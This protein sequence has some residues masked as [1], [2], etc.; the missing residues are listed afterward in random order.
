MAIGYLLHSSG[1]Q[2]VRD[3]GK[4]VISDGTP[5]PDCDC[6]AADPCDITCYK[7]LGGGFAP[8]CITIAVAGLQICTG[9]IGFKNVISGDPGASSDYDHEQ[10]GTAPNGSY[11]ARLYTHDLHDSWMY[12]QP[13]GGPVSARSRES[14]SSLWFDQLSVD[15]DLFAGGVISGT[16][17]GHWYVIV[18]VSAGGAGWYSDP[19]EVIRDSCG[20]LILDGTTG[21]FHG[22][23]LPYLVGGEQVEADNCGPFTMPF[24]ERYP[25]LTQ[26]WKP[27]NITGGTFSITQC[28]CP[29]ETGRC[30]NYFA[31]D[32]FCE[33]STQGPVR[34]LGS[35]CTPKLTSDYPVWTSLSPV[36]A[37]IVTRII[38]ILG[39]ICLG[40]GFCAELLDLPDPPAFRPPECKVQ[41]EDCSTCCVPFTI[42]VTGGDC[43]GVYVMG[44]TG[45]FSCTYRGEDGDGVAYAWCDEDGWHVVIQKWVTIGPLRVLKTCQFDGSLRDC[46]DQVTDWECTSG[47]TESPSIDVTCGACTCTCT[48]Y[49]VSGQRAFGTD[50][51]PLT[52]NVTDPV[53]CLFEPASLDFCPPTPVPDSIRIVKNPRGGE[54]C[55]WDYEVSFPSSHITYHLS[56]DNPV[57]TYNKIDDTTGA[58]NS[59]TVV[60][61]C[62]SMMMG[63]SRG[64]GDTLKKLF[65]AIGV[66]P[67]TDCNKRASKLNQ[68]FPYKR[69]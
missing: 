64:F 12:F 66:Q 48:S 37:I 57:G 16:L 6:A 47:C 33:T 41:C 60:V 1:K 53:S 29:C 23:F 18:S 13:R 26:Y 28:D 43:S 8:N 34:R 22:P 32:Y 68:V 3:G 27:P 11:C 24:D 7:G 15:A 31:S 42:R 59:S 50:C 62:L 10:K 49:Q 19:I 17:A 46:I 5:C 63:K 55:G 14:P 58:D 52:L 61:T 35:A 30:H 40:A 69:Q 51:P 54:S 2:F 56:G 21:T 20:R 45:N 25:L 9:L 65:K 39:G 44:Q 36:G 67:C 38:D 4:H